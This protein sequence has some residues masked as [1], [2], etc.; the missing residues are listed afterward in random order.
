[1]GSILVEGGGDGLTSVIIQH[2]MLGLL[3]IFKL[4]FI[5]RPD[6]DQPAAGDQAERKDNQQYDAFIHN[7]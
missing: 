3:H 2:A 5:N 7:V 1:M 4:P 6:K